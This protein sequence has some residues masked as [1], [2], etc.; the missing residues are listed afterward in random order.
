MLTQ[1]NPI[2]TPLARA[3][4]RPMAADRFGEEPR[5]AGL[6]R[7]AYQTPAP[8]AQI[9]SSLAEPA[10]ITSST[11]DFGDFIDMINPLQ[12][13]PL[14]NMAYRA[15][16]GD[17]IGGAAQIVGGA[18][19]GGPIGALAGTASAIIEH[20]TGASPAQTVFSAF[21]GKPSAPAAARTYVDLSAPITKRYN[22]NQSA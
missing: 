22:F 8:Q 4:T 7:V 1:F 12:H 3:D 20:Q 10:E 11:T 9:A 2:Q 13:I 14:V 18:L 21:T 16:T 17:E 15:L 5:T 6:S 19:F